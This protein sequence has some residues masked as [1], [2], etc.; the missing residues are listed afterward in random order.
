[1]RLRQVARLTIS[2]K[3]ILKH[4]NTTTLIRRH[5]KSA[6]YVSVKAVPR[7]HTRMT[8]AFKRVPTCHIGSAVHFHCTAQRSFSSSLILL[9]VTRLFSKLPRFRKCLHQNNQTVKLFCHFL[10]SKSFIK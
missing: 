3:N 1:M 5:K 8:R 6:S 10:I 4:Y 2:S 7:I 9:R